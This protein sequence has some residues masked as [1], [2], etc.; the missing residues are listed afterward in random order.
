[1]LT[2]ARASGAQEEFRVQMSWRCM[3]FWAPATPPRARTPQTQRRFAGDGSGEGVSAGDCFH[4]EEVSEFDGVGSVK[5]QPI[6]AQTSSCDHEDGGPDSVGA[7]C[8]DGGGVGG[9]DSLAG[10]GGSD[11]LEGAACSDG[12]GASCSA[13]LSPK[14]EGCVVD[15][16]S[17]TSSESICLQTPWLRH[18]LPDRLAS[19]AKSGA[20]RPWSCLLPGPTWICMPQHSPF[21]WPF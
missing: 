8:W 21:P 15:T 9:S 4:G 14:G 11:S 16:P 13:A 12:G 5:D 3:V 6:L 2:V 20:V 18:P 7:A 17:L 19:P 10:A 1:M